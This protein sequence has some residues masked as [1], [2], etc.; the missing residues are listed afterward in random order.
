MGGRRG[1]GRTQVCLIFQNPHMLWTSPL[2]PGGHEMGTRAPAGITYTLVHLQICV[3]WL[4]PSSTSPLHRPGC[5]HYHHPAHAPRTSALLAAELA[6][7]DNG[8]SLVVP[9]TQHSTTQAP[10]FAYCPAAG[11]GGDKG[12]APTGAP[13]AKSGEGAEGWAHDLRG[14]SEAAQR[15]EKSEQ[16]VVDATRQGAGGLWSRSSEVL[17]VFRGGGAPHTSPYRTGLPR[18]VPNNWLE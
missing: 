12:P 18:R 6:A 10:F 4:L 15:R 3:V 11:P 1:K 5:S 13:Y 14:H 9:M 8:K 17:D 2:L 16:A 7:R